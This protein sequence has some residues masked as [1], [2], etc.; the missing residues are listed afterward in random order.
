MVFGALMTVAVALSAAVIVSGAIGL[1]VTSLAQF[2]LLV[3]LALFLV[4][5]V[6]G[7]MGRRGS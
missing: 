1:S 2:L 6:R 4:N 5:L 3:V 7:L